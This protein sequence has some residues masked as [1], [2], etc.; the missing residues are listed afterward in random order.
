MCCLDKHVKWRT[1]AVWNTVRKKKSGKIEQDRKQ[2]KKKK[3][4]ET[5]GACGAQKIND[6]TMCAT[7]E[8]CGSLS[9]FN[10]VEAERCQNLAGPLKIILI[11]QRKQNSVLNDL[12]VN[13]ASFY[14]SC[15]SFILDRCCVHLVTPTA[16]SNESTP[17]LS[18]S[19]FA[20]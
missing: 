19:Q 10:T 6:Q 7:N 14:R 1:A 16:G 13:T 9:R 4:E 5:E 17:V 11:Q 18:P 12:E 20:L 2:K 15:L 3:E 8:N